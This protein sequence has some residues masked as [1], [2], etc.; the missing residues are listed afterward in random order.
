[1]HFVITDGT[2]NYTPIRITA[3]TVVEDNRRNRN[4]LESA[5]KRA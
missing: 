4:Q 3:D 1:M 5:E 2:V